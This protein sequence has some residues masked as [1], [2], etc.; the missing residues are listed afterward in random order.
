MDT[1]ASSEPIKLYLDENTEPFK[2]AQAPLRFNFT[3]M[4]LA[5]GEHTLRIEASNGLAPPTVRK[6]PFQVRNG[7]AVTVT[8]LQ[9]NQTIGGQVELIINAYAGNTEVDF[10]PRKAE[11]P[12]PIPTWAWVLFLGVIA[13]TMFYVLNPAQPPST[14]TA[15]V[16]HV[17]RDLGVRIYGDLC[18]RCHGEDGSGRLVHGVEEGPKRDQGDYRVPFLRDDIE[19]AL[20][21]TPYPLLKTVLIGKPRSDLMRPWGEELT[22][23]EI[24]SVVNYV[25]TAWGHNA[26]VIRMNH[27]RPPREIEQLEDRLKEAITSSKSIAERMAQLTGCCWPDATPPP[28]E[29]LRPLLY[30]TDFEEKVPAVGSRRVEDEWR[31]YFERVGE[32]GR[33]RIYELLEKQYHYDPDTVDQDGSIVIGMGSLFVDAVSACLDEER[34]KGRFIRVYQRAAGKWYM[35]LDFADIP[36]DI[37]CMTEEDFQIRNVPLV[38]Y[39]QIQELFRSLPQ[40]VVHADGPFEAF[41]EFNHPTFVGYRARLADSSDAQPEYIRLVTPGNAQTSNLIKLLKDGKDIV[42]EGENTLETRRVDRPRLPVT[43][44]LLEEKQVNTIARWINEGCPEVAPDPTGTTPTGT[45]TDTPPIRTAGDWPVATVSFEQVVDILVGFNKTAKGAIHGHFWEKPYQEFVDY[46]FDYELG[47]DEKVALVRPGEPDKSNLLRALSADPTIILTLPDGSTRETQIPRMPKGG[48]KATDEQL[49]TIR[50]WIEEGCP[51]KTGEK[52]SQ[53]APGA[54]P[55]G[56]GAAVAST[57]TGPAPVVDVGFQEVIDILVGFNKTAKGAIHGH[58]WEKPY[59]EFVAFKFDYELGSDDKVWLVV[60]GSADDSNLLRALSADTSILV[61]Q[62]DGTTREERV[63][64]MPKGGKKATDAELATI[65]TWI[66]AGCP[67]KAGEPSALWGQP[68]PGRAG[69][70]S[71]GGQDNKPAEGGGFP[72]PGGGSGFPDPGGGSGFP[73]PGGG[74]DGGGFPDPGGGGGFPPPD[75][76]NKPKE[77][78]D[79]GGFPPPGGGGFPPPGGGG[80]GFPPPDGGR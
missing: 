49:A 11:T 60:P 6:I 8:G 16:E 66:D 48:T 68:L 36:M 75:D 27:D 19:F 24:I 32:G 25:R 22:N 35:V 71:R 62:A 51:E 7:V 53:P 31:R 78:K 26:S 5:D 42:V 13:W 14:A 55:A 54:A 64:R 73:D 44:P 43:G 1:P 21:E 74:D 17:S 58:F 70:G 45:G 76:G 39:E 3:T 59:A 18:A 34:A 15:Q 61:T 79:P 46:V 50:T 69:T 12:Q 10:E 29:L 63:P 40:P 23:D 41:W 20:A 4:H 9:P 52:S 28:P 67:E 38:G 77:P 47:S 30:R 37:G 80:G 57:M 33:V 56:G 2:V 65:R 72:D